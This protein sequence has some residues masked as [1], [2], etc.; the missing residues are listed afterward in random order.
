MHL[1]LFLVLFMDMEER[2]PEKRFNI[3]AVHRVPFF[4]ENRVCL[5]PHPSS[6]CKPNSL[7]GAR[8]EFII[9]RN[10]RE[11]CCSTVSRSGIECL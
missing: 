2:D 9:Y 6:F 3:Y 5:L 4:L 8:K 7:L 11:T 10:Y 1:S